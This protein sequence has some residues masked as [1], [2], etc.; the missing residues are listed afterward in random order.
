MKSSSDNSGFHFEVF[1]RADGY[2]MVSREYGIVVRNTSIEA[3]VADLKSRIKAARDDFDALGIPSRSSHDAS[4]P[5]GGA[6]PGQPRQ[7]LQMAAIAMS[8]VA[9]LAIA[10]AY[11]TVSFLSGIKQTISSVLPQGTEVDSA[12]RST[13]DLVKRIANATEQITPE[14]ERE[15]Q[16]SLDKIA[17]KVAPLI[18]AVTEPLATT[19]STPP[20]CP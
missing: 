16:E 11:P 17:R 2:A 5:N 12:G 10:A 14:R 1:Q 8:I 9:V 20:S 15:L 3:G 6:A 4:V 13:I 19:P 7:P 18:R